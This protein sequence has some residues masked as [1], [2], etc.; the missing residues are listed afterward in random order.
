[1]TG[2]AFSG[3]V[4]AVA[5]AAGLLLAL[6]GLLIACRA[7]AAPAV[8][9][10][11]S[12]RPD[13]QVTVTQTLTQTL[14]VVTSPGGIGAADVEVEP[15]VWPPRLVIRL[16]LAGLEQFRLI[17]GDTII[18]AAAASVGQPVIMQQ[19]SRVSAPQV[20]ETLTDASRFWLPV[21]LATATGAGAQIPFK[22]GFFELELPPDFWAGDYRSFHF[23]WIDFYR[24]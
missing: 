16:H 11:T 23:E 24:G 1:M 2:A 5:S 13:T 22:N 18:T 6:A 19:M 3:F 8:V 7:P 10:A 12:R 21:R 15:G 17:Y 4:K 14:L 20:E 9:S